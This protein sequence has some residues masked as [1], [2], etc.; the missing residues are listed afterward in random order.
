[1]LV[2]VEC[3][4]LVRDGIVK[5]WDDPRMSTV[6]GMRR[7]GYTKE[8]L[9]DFCDR[10]GVAKANSVVDFALLEACVR[11]DLNKKAPRAM[12]VLRPVKLVID[13]YPEGETEEITV[14]INPEDE[15][16][17]TRKVLFSRNL[18]VEADD[19]ME[20]PPKK[21]F[22]LAIGNEVRL[23]GAYYVTCN[24]VEKDADGNVT[25]IHCTYDPE[26]K[27]GQSPD[28]RKVRGTIHWAC[29]EDSVDAEVRLYE[30]LF[31]V[32]NPSDEE[33]NGDY[34]TNLNPESETILTGC[35]L[36]KNIA[37]AKIGDTFQFMRMG[38]FCVDPDSADGKLV[39]NR[40]VGLKDS[41]SKIVKKD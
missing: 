24:S 32:E 5:G 36:E 27:G 1:M 2:K 33:T 18:Y 26:S 34:L 10:I 13:N 38:Y 6:C 29:E 17:G 19:Y 40:T 37:D 21:Y 39:F 22:R 16:A 35:K 41:W 11:E 28:G 20:N 15:N 7:R 14:E 25:V 3:L 30:R 4:K 23:K 8:A 12:A 31:N 9:R